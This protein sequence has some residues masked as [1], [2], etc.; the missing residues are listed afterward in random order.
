[1]KHYLEEGPA[2]SGP[3]QKYEEAFLS[4]AYSHF[5]GCGGEKISLM[6][7]AA[8]SIIHSM[9]AASG[10]ISWKMIHCGKGAQRE[11]NL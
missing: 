8:R 11:R 1:M 4:F 6:W 10:N 2:S 9:Y 3:R 7:Y 5:P